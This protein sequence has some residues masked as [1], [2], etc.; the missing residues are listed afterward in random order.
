MRADDEMDI[1]NL[2]RGIGDECGS[3]RRS[4]LAFESSVFIIDRIRTGAGT[5]TKL[6]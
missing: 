5:W 6:L 4:L 1:G 2:F 3:A